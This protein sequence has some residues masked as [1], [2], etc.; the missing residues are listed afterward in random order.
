MVCWHHAR[1][2]EGAKDLGEAVIKACQQPTQFKFL[3][4]LDISIKVHAP[5]ELY[6]LHAT[7]VNADQ[8][9]LLT[10]RLFCHQ[11]R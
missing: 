1:G 7:Y 6:L 4:P 8:H 11:L 5:A 2:G 9:Q 10:K 3:Y